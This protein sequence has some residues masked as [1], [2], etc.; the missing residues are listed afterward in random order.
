MFALVATTHVFAS[1]HT[2]HHT[3]VIFVAGEE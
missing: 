1:A 3:A 2:Q